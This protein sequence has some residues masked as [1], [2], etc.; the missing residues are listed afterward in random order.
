MD[1]RDG[2]PGRQDQD[3]TVDLAF[4]RDLEGRNALL[5]SIP[6]P[7]IVTDSSTGIVLELND[8][9][10]SLLGVQRESVL[11]KTPAE[12]GIDLVVDFSSG[13][14][15]GSKASVA[16]VTDSAGAR[17]ACRLFS[18]QVDVG[19]RRVMISVLLDAT[20]ESLVKGRSQRQKDRKPGSEDRREAAPAPGGKPVVLLVDPTE[21]TR[22]SEE[23]MLNMLGFETASGASAAEALTVL[24]SGRKKP[25]FI[26]L[27]YL[28]VDREEIMTI[29]GALPGAS[30]LVALPDGT[31]PPPGYAPGPVVQ[32]RRPLS[33][34]ELAD[35]VS[36]LLG[37]S[38]AGGG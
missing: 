28:G 36:K 21:S 32:I 14:R 8:S 27:D 26:L 9:A 10:L 33:I 23:G 24:A 19:R 3:G 35:A 37:R 30:Y 15:T 6:L 25:A 31:E 7:V 17:I 12:A 5:R 4:V 16:I 38:S 2:A 20:L 34:N 22:E 13:A 18:T 29:S 11:E 1:P